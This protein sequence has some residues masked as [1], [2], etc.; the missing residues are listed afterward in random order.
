MVKI[1]YV[2]DY[3]YLSNKSNQQSYDKVTELIKRDDVVLIDIRRD[4]TISAIDIVKKYNPKIIIQE[5]I[6]QEFKDQLIDMEKVEVKCCLTLGDCYKCKPERLDK[7]D[8]ILT[9]FW[10]NTVEKLDKNTSTKF[11][12]IPM[13]VNKKVFKNYYLEKKYDVLLYGNCYELY[14]PVRLAIKKGV[15]QSNLKVKIITIEDNIFEEKLAKLICESKYV[16]ATPSIF[17]H[18]SL[19]YFEA[20]SCG[21][22]IIG[23]YP[24][25]SVDYTRGINKWIEDILS[26]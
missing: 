7:W 5:H 25:V 21:T 18:Q 13:C 24:Q 6:Q 19:R 23:Y 9:M 10:N 2:C 20:E 3:E 11:K 12:L 4:D 17:D 15:L 16:V 1:A 14:Y 26:I 22:P 8:L